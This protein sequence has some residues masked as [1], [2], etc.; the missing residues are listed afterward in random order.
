[1]KSFIESCMLFIFF[2]FI[3]IAVSVLFAFP[4]KWMWNYVMP[5]L[6]NLREIDF[7]HALALNFLCGF[8]FKSMNFNK[9]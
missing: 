2:C 7:K 1:M 3:V 5:Y 6:F 4:V 9:K 8:L